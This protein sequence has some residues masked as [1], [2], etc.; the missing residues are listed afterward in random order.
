MTFSQSI[1]TCFNKY[2]VFK[3]RASRSEYWW[4]TLFVFLVEFVAVFVV[5]LVAN[6]GAGTIVNYILS[7][8]FLLP[9]LAVAVRRYHDT[10]HSGWWVLCPIVNIILLFYASDAGANDY[11][12]LEE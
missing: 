6:E 3:G 11:G 12:T 10:N 4:W 7:L 9:N 2:A 1:S 5:T 8:V